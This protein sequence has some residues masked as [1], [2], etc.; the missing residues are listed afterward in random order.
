MGSGCA[1]LPVNGPGL[2]GGCSL[3]MDHG[4]LD[5]R[6]VEQSHWAPALGCCWLL[7]AARLAHDCLPAS[8]ACFSYACLPHS[9]TYSSESC[10]MSVTQSAPGFA[11]FCRWRRIEVDLSEPERKKERNTH[12]GGQVM[13]CIAVLLCTG[14]VS[15]A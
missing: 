6:T 8:S 2:F 7:A 11:G 15:L 13:H 3:S 4:A 5:S 10:Q 12:D 9:R 1:A 14:P